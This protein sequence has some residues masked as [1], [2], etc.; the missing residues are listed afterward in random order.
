MESDDSR[1]AKEMRD[2]ASEDRLFRALHI[3]RSGNLNAEEFDNEG[4]RKLAVELRRQELISKGERDHFI[5][6]H[7]GLRHVRLM[8]YTADYHKWWIVERDLFR[9]TLRK[10]MVYGSRDQAM[11][12]SGLDY[13]QWIE[14]TD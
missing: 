6:I 11:T 14:Y 8:F 9:N 4:D 10:S 7:Q 12:A 3:K 13:I 1:R 2:Q 5:V